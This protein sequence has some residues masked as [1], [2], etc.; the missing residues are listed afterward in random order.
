MAAFS[1]AE[2]HQKGES[3]ARAARLAT[4][5]GVPRLLTIKAMADRWGVQVNTDEIGA[6]DP[7]G[8]PSV[9]ARETATFA[10][11]GLVAAY[12]GASF[13]DFLEFERR[14]RIS[15]KIDALAMADRVADALAFYDRLAPGS[16]EI[17]ELTEDEA[18]AIA[19]DHID[20]ASGAVRIQDESTQT[21]DW[22]WLFLYQSAAYLDTGDFAQ[23]IAGN[24]PLII[25]RFTGALWS[26]GT[27]SRPDD[28]IERYRRTG[29]PHPS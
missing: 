11:A 21:H 8:Y 9:A 24:A 26:T 16:L 28:Y 5:A 19:A 25:D 22:G 14:T 23:M 7:G 10:L 3:S 29:T 17:I 4:E 27:A 12:P 18:R 6:A 15:T 20:E 1:F 2:L 13:G